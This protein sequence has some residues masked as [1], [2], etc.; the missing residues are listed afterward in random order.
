M[1][2]K[3]DVVKAYN[4]TEDLNASRAYLSDDF[5]S[6]DKDGKVVMNK[7]AYIGMGHMLLASLPDF[8][9]VRSDLRQEGDYVIMTGHFQGTHKADLDLSAMGLGVIPASGKEIVWPE[10][11]VK[12]TVEGGKIVREEPYGELDGMKAFLM[13]LGVELPSA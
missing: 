3:L 1:T 13:G 11:S 8:R 7:E 5:Q 4:D 9:F 12:F 2:N 10:V 6:V